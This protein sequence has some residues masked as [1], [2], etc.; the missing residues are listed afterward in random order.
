MDVD[1]VHNNLQNLS[2]F[3]RPNEKTSIGI[4]RSFK[5]RKSTHSL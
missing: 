3:I 5:L 2:E 4:D 1:N